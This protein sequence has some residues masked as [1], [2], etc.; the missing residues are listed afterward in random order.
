MQVLLSMLEK[1]LKEELERGEQQETNKN[2]TMGNNKPV[3]TTRP[4]EKGDE[5]MTN[6]CPAFR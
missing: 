6:L 5:E 4:N 1:E 2:V 3:S